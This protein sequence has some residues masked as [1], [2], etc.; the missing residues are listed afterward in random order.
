MEIL[1]VSVDGYSDLNASLSPGSINAYLHRV[2][3]FFENHLPQ[4]IS[5]LNIGFARKEEPATF[6]A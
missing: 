1:F 2:R 6:K 3:R 5:L 4:L